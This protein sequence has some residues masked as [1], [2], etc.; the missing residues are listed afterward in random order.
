MATEKKKN[1]SEK[2]LEWRYGLVAPYINPG[3]RVLDLGA[4]TGWVGKRIAERKGCDV[5]LVDVLDCNETDLPHSVY[6]GHTVPFAD[7]EFDVCLLMFVL[8][9]ALN[10]EEILREAARVT[11]RRIVLVEDTPRN[12]VERAIDSLCDTLMSLE[13]GFFNPANYRRIEGWRAIFDQMGLALR[14]QDV[15]PPFFPFYYTK[16]V[17]AL[18][19]G[20][21]FPDAAA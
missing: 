3:E 5:R 18:D 19:P 2:L 1:T 17:F 7:K 13:H 15:V 4:G 9:H 6:D 11:R 16:A 12:F 14:G 10:Q 8:H 21:A 20:P